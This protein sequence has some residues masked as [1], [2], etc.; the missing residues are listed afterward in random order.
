[1]PCQAAQALSKV[2][3]VIVIVISFLS[4][5]VPEDANVKTIS[6]LTLRQVF[7]WLR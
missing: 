6:G 1:M 7:T 3:G 2:V 5:S 4:V